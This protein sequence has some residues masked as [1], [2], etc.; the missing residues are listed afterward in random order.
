[1]TVDDVGRLDANVFHPLN[2]G[3]WDAADPTG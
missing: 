3:A 1:M 2:P